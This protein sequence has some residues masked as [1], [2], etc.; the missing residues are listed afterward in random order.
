MPAVIWQSSTPGRSLRKLSRR[1]R[2][3]LAGWRTMPFCWLERKAC[4]QCKI[5]CKSLQLSVEPVNPSVYSAETDEQGSCFTELVYTTGDVYKH[6]VGQPLAAASVS[7]RSRL[8][9]M[10]NNVDAQRC[11]DS[12]L[13]HPSLNRWVPAHPEHPCS[14]PSGQPA[15]TSTKY[16]PASSPSDA[17]FA[18]HHEW[19][20]SS[21]SKPG[22]HDGYGPRAWGAATQGKNRK[23][24]DS[25]AELKDDACKAATEAGQAVTESRRA[26]DGIKELKG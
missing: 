25:L 18:G 20:Q 26:T 2:L 11:S 15:W 12:G 4:W 16:E 24:K 8:T 17:H 21:S 6:F 9:S 14:R 1:T 13:S 22:N 23:L 5:S 7:S 3:G 10:Q 19:T